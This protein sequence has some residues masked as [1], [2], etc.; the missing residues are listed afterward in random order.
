VN[1]SLAGFAIV[2]VVGRSRATTRT[3]RDV[4]SALSFSQSAA[5]RRDSRS[6]CS[7]RRTSPG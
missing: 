7:I 6:T 1:S 3:R 4:S 2:Q 5:V